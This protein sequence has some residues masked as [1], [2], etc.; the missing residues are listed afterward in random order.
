[1]I[2]SVLNLLIVITVA[3]TMFAAAAPE[4]YAAER[5]LSPPDVQAA[6]S[7]G[8]IKSLH[9]IR[10]MAHV[11]EQL[12]AVADARVCEKNGQPYYFVNVVGPSG[13]STTLVLNAVDGSN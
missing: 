10:I 6:I 3:S 7:E 13:D 5:C 4:A 12:K 9:D 11:P 1:M 8:R 2:N